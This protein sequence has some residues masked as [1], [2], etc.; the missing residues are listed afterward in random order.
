MPP[1]L[2]R[3]PLIPLSPLTQASIESAEC[4]SKISQNI[5]ESPDDVLLQKHYSPIR[6]KL[7]QMTKG[8]QA[9]QEKAFGDF[10]YREIAKEIAYIDSQLFRLVVLDDSWLIHFDKRVNAIPLL[11]FHRFLSHV[12]AHEVICSSKESNKTII[13]QLIQTAS[14]LLFTYRDFSGCTA[15]LECLQMPEVQRIE[16][17]WN[18]CPPK[19]I[20][21]FKS[22]LPILSPEENYEN[23]INTLG[24]LTL[25]FLQPTQDPS[26]RMVAIPFLQAHL[27]I[28]YRVS[29]TLQ[30]LKFCQRNLAIKPFSQKSMQGAIKNTNLDIVQSNPNIYHWLVSRPYLTLPQLYCEGLQSVPLVTGEVLEKSEPENDLYWKFHRV[31]MNDTDDEDEEEAE[32]EESRAA[33]SY[34]PELEAE[35]NGNDMWI[36][37]E[38]TQL[39]EEITHT[40][41]GTISEDIEPYEVIEGADTYESI[42]KQID[43][44]NQLS[45]SLRKNYDPKLTIKVPDS[46]ANQVDLEPRTAEIEHKPTLSASAPEF[47]P[48]SVTNLQI[49]VN[50]EEWKGYPAKETEEEDDDDE[51]WKGYPVSNTEVQ[52]E[53]EDEVWKGYP[54][55]EPIKDGWS[56]SFEPW[57][58]GKPRPFGKMGL[59]RIQHSMSS[60][61]LP[62]SERKKPPPLFVSTSAST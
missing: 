10:D 47:V 35:P 41:L 19:M 38:R 1:N 45:S 3:L 55:P 4:L 13:H 53:D 26:S 62:S 24:S 49:E 17:A 30:I 54:A 32:G 51:E 2:T 36:P 29:S 23:Y 56:P 46:D 57:D 44:V 40:E 20:K 33:K 34:S 43:D 52:E 16:N 22:L 15:I 21:A 6:E 14:T 9:I 27:D 28:M 42:P 25:S 59:N 11:D 31:E 48:T 18:E 60:N 39:E 37:V 7:D 12:F 8:I 58:K 61:I 50:D 5:S